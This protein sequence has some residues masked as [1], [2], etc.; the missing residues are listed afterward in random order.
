[1]ARA[2]FL[3][4]LVF[5][6]SGQEYDGSDSGARPDEAVSWGKIKIDATPVKVGQRPPPPP[7]SRPV[8]GTRT[9]PFERDMVA[10]PV[11]EIL[12]GVTI[13]CCC[14]YRGT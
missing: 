2:A 1:M 13:F 8:R 6:W 5:L 3:E 9:P 7:G 11:C 10:V 4:T 12:G 14:C